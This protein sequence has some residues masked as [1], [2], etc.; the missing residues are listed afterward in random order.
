M[1]AKKETFK[2][3]SSFIIS[4]HCREIHKRS[5]VYIGRLGGNFVGTEFE[6]YT[7]RGGVES[8][9]VKISY[10]KNII[11]FMG[12][13]SFRVVKVDPSV[14]QEKYGAGLAAVLERNERSKLVE[15][16]TVRPRM[17]R[18]RYRLDFGGRVRVP[19]AKNFIL[20]EGLGSVLFGGV[21][22]DRYVVEVGYP[23]S[24][25]EAFGVCLS[26]LD[27]KMLVN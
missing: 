18:G 6:L 14:A 8:L 3:C 21:G 17:V 7:V 15:L 1:S 5:E 26:S 24:L 12:P 20:G 13:R 11:G 4:S 10:E 2:Y 16:T 27:S 23:F 25:F 9:R 22:V 19:S